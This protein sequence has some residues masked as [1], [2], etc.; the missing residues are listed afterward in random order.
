M[1]FINLSGEKIPIAEK[2]T[3]SS[4]ASFITRVSSK[5]SREKFVGGMLQF[6]VAK[7]AIMF[8]SALACLACK[9]RNDR[10]GNYANRL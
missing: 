3:N 2:N 7:S 8:T 5:E 10:V 6:C 4:S 9:S 1:Q